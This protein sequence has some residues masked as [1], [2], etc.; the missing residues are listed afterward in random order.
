M[1][2]SWQTIC[3]LLMVRSTEALRVKFAMRS[4]PPPMVWSL[5]GSV[6]RLKMLNRHSRRWSRA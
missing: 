4:A 1:Q 2:V 3:T 5:P 6:S